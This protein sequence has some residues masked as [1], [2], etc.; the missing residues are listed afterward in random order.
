METKSD[1]TLALDRFEPHCDMI[2]SAKSV[3]RRGLTLIEVLV[4]I[5]IVG[6]LFALF[7]PHARV[8]REA[9]RRNQSICNLKQFTL[10]I[11]NHY[12][13]RKSLPLASTAPLIQAN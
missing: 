1:K 8:S 7:V 9:A 4:I 6:I 11:Q 12:D 2:R 3:V 13:V 5:A 10:A